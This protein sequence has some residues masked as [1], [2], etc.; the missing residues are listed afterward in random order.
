M[1]KYSV[2]KKIN[3]CLVYGMDSGCVTTIITVIHRGY[4]MAVQRYEISLQVLKSAARTSEIFF[5]MRREILY[6]LMAM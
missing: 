3:S 6:L 4:Y 5:N 1:H 2:L